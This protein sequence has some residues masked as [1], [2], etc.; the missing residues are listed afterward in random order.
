[1]NS[2]KLNKMSA[3]LT[4]IIVSNDSIHFM[5][6]VE[7]FTYVGMLLIGGGEGDMDISLKF[8]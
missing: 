4:V 7:I 6:L 5:H 2:E 8:R 1:M 3:V